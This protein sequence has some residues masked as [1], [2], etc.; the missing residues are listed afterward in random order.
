M[1]KDVVKYVQSCYICQQC[2][3]LQ[4]HSAGYME[5]REVYS[6][7]QVVACD[8]IG[9][10]PRSKQGY[11]HVVIFED[12]FTKWIEAVLLHKKNAKSIVNAFKE[13][14]LYRHGVPEK[15]I[16]VMVLSFAII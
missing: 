9:P 2:K 16:S 1:H 3:P 13:R 12:L 8:C 14:I 4:T 6:P 5:K 15:F 7:W 10:F 11:T